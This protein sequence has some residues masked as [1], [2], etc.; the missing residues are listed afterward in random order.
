MGT[1]D[2]FVPTRL[3]KQLA[4]LILLTLLTISVGAVLGALQKG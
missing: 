4:T 2:R 1:W 3:G